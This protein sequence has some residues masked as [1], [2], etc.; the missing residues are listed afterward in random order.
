MA[1]ASLELLKGSKKSTANELEKKPTAKAKQPAPEPE[2]APEPEETEAGEE[3][4]TIEVEKM[5]SKELDALVAEHEIEVPDEWKKWP[6]AKKRSWLNEQFGNSEDTEAATEASDEAQEAVSEAPAEAQPETADGE[7]TGATVAE[8]T[9]SPAEKPAKGKASKS[10][11]LAPAAKALEGELMAPDALS[12]LVHEIENLKQKDALALVGQL[13]EQSE[14]TYFKLGGVLSVIQANG[15]FE[16]YAS[17]RE[18][19]E[20]EHGIH[21]RKAT[22]WVAIYNDLSESGVPWDKVKS[23]GWTKLKEIASIIKPDNVDEWVKIAQGQ[24]TLQLIETVSAH[25]KKQAQGQLSDQSGDA[26][27]KTVTTMTFKVHEDQKET[28]KAAIDKAK[29]ESGTNVDSVA[30]EFICLDYMGSTAKLP[31]LQEQMKSAGMEAAL[32]ALAAAFPEAN[33][34]VELPDDEADAA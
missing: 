6:V 26:E 13:S 25:K 12:D 31:N 8:N 15:W 1:A 14:F 10:K 32:E 11:A 2:A 5:S 22:Y 29:K 19:V 17:F 7:E 24:T 20:K 9:P 34:S 3:Q 27:V 18:Y 33:F 23:L 30:L 21:Y 16:P 28:V 4:V